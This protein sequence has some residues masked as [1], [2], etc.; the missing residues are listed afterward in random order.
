MSDKHWPVELAVD[1]VDIHAVNRAVST[2]SPEQ[3]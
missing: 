3:V 1:G 2:A